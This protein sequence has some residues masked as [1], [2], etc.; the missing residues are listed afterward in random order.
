[1]PVDR[2][3]VKKHGQ[4]KR[5]WTNGVSTF[6]WGGL[7]TLMMALPIKAAETISLTYGPLEFSLEVSALASFA[8]EGIVD[9]KL[10][11]YMRLAQVNDPEK[12]QLFRQA[13]LENADVQPTLLTRFLGTEI[14]QDV[15]TRFGN[16]ITLPNGNNG[17]EALKEGILQAATSPQGLTLLNVLQNLPSDIKIDGQKTLALSERAKKVVE[18]TQRFS[19]ELKQLSAAEVAQNP[20]APW[21]KTPQKYLMVIE[22]QAHVDLSELDAG[23]TEVINSVPGLTLPSPQLLDGYLNAMIVAF[24]EVYVA[25]DAAYRPYLQ[26]A[27]LDYLSRGERFHA[28]LITQASSDRLR[29]EIEGFKAE[30]NL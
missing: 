29:Q 8:K 1:M 14:G 10:E 24:S 6:A 21:L 16:L 3:G 19:D 12:R 2:Q 15:L 20:S 30:N 27:Y 5:S 17:N 13:L 22:G 11:Q 28:F 9:P 4:F 26:P 23:V 7:T 18:A 25:R